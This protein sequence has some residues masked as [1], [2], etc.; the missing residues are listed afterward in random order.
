MKKLFFDTR[1][2]DAAARNKFNLTEKSMMEQAAAALEK[3][4]YE[5]IA[6]IDDGRI[7]KKKFEVLILCGS[8]NNGGDGYAL[9]SR[10]ADNNTDKKII[11]VVFQAAEP[12]SVMCIEEAARAEKSGVQFYKRE[13]TNSLSENILPDE[14]ECCSVV[15]D[16]VFGAGFHGILDENTACLMNHVNKIDCV[17][18]T[19]DVPTGLAADG[20]ADKSSFNADFT[21]TMGALKA[22]L[23]SDEAKD[24]CGE[25]SC[26]DLGVTRDQFENSAPCGDKQNDNAGAPCAFVLEEKDL[27]LPHRTK[28]IVN[29]GTFGHAVIARGD[30][31]GAAVIA[32]SAALRYGAGLVTLVHLRGAEITHADDAHIA[33]DICAGKDTHASKGDAERTEH[34]LHMPVISDTAG[35][36]IALPELMMSEQMSANTASVALGMG[37]GRTIDDAAPYFAWLEAHPEIPCVLDADVFYNKEIINFVAERVQQSQQSQKNRTK[38]EKNKCDDETKKI[39]DARVVLTPHPKEFQSL[40]SLAGLGDYSV[41]DCVSKRIDLV[42]KFCEL[43][44]GVVLLVKGA[45]PVIGM[46]QTILINPFGMPCLAKAGSGDVLSGLICSLLAQYSVKNEAA[47]LPEKEMMPLS[48][49]AAVQGSLAHALA[50]TLVPCDYAMTPFTLIDCTAKLAD[51]FKYQSS[52]SLREASMADIKSFIKKLKSFFKGYSDVSS[53]AGG[54]GYI[55]PHTLGKSP[56]NPE[57]YKSPCDQ[58]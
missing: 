16:C 45:N 7:S 17:R 18:I 33:L 34:E 37:L 46:N 10:I 11:P 20:T 40:L 48:L 15:I 39:I 14:C 57:D 42:K 8:G 6:S 43:F 1:V 44:P 24:I 2:L 9:A 51:T 21:V 4:V 32:G 56:V 28:K 29:K 55:A 50:S 19:C 49:A 13:I 31:G 35:N 12:K 5:I 47:V 41:A 54:C 58:N 3:K 52:S 23:Y 30:K 53:H 27:L 22:S 26:A 38:I 25:I 36:S